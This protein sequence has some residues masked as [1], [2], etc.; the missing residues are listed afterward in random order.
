MSL[1]DSIMANTVGVLFSARTGNVDPWT[2]ANQQEDLAASIAQAKGPNADP[3]DV[4]I[5]QAAA[6]KEQSDYLK[7]I[8]EHPD[9]ACGGITLPVIGCVDGDNYLAYVNKIVYG[10]IFVGALVGGFWLY[11]SYGSTFKHAFRKR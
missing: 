6:I 9:Q 10:A 3:A 4:A 5:A 7:S 1:Y 2:L 11:Q 8:G